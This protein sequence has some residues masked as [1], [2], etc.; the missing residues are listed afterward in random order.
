[1]DPE[2]ASSEQQAASLGLGVDEF[3]QL[4]SMQTHLD[5]EAATRGVDAPAATS[6][7][8]SSTSS[9]AAAA[10]RELYGVAEAE[11]YEQVHGLATTTSHATQLLSVEVPHGMQGGQ[12]IQVQSPAGLRI[13][14]P[15]PAGLVAGQ[16]FSVRMAVAPPPPSADPPGQPEALAALA[17]IQETRALAEQQQEEQRRRRSSEHAAQRRSQLWAST[18]ALIE[19]AKKEDAAGNVEAALRTYDELVG[20]METLL[21]YESHPEMVRVIHE[22]N[23]QFNARRLELA[24]AHAPR[25]AASAGGSQPA[26]AG[27]GSRPAS[28]PADGGSRPRTPPGEAADTGQLLDTAR[29]LGELAITADERGDAPDAMRQYSDA[30]EAY[31]R[32]A[33]NASRAYARGAVAPFEPA[34]RVLCMRSICGPPHR[35]VEPSRT[36]ACP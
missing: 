29:R 10:R 28:P 21:E 26:S 25:Q 8:H 36:S 19:T 11:S 15:I 30:A 9:D 34:T 1:M 13:T 12:H 4:R 7:R 20:T 23:S 31:M 2:R 32:C 33:S 17:R 6:G 35:A 3:R 5:A 14:V 27:G 16:R 24:Q 18:E 22:K